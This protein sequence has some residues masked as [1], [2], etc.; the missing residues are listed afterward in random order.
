MNKLKVGDYVFVRGINKNTPFGYNPDMDEWEGKI[1]IIIGIGKGITNKGKRYNAYFLKPF[2]WESKN[3]WDPYLYI[4]NRHF[5][6]INS[7]YW[8][9]KCLKK[10]T[11]DEIIAYSI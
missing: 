2:N 6:K 7:W 9:R 10:L 3:G 5:D 4:S 8:Y 1:G 11:D